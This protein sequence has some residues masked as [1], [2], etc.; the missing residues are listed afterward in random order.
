MKSRI[1]FS[2][3]AVN[4]TT[5]KGIAIP[6]SEDLF[7]LVGLHGLCSQ[8]NLHKFYEL[9][10]L[11]A[12]EAVKFAAYHCDLRSETAHQR[13]KRFILLDLLIRTNFSKDEAYIKTTFFFNGSWLNDLDEAA[14][15]S[16]DLFEM[17][18]KNALEIVEI[19]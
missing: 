18:Y 2:D 15:S 19:K 6:I 3:G 8:E 4:L 17:V 11:E 1:Q 5:E 7:H 10:N 16:T 13:I 12:K 14:Y 9:I